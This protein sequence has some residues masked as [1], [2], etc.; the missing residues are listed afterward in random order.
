MRFLS[1]VNI[2]RFAEYSLI[3][4]SAIADDDCVIPLWTSPF[5]VD[6]N[7]SGEFERWKINIGGR[8]TS[9]GRTNYYHYTGS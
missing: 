1:R 9:G 4:A 6:D 7:R 8:A 3:I 5:R 2:L